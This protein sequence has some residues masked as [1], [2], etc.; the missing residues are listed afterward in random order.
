[1]KYPICCFLLS[2][3]CFS[4]SCECLFAAPAT[5]EKKQTV[6]TADRMSYMQDQNVIFFEE[7]VKVTNPDYTMT[8]RKMTVYLKDKKNKS[9]NKGNGNGR[10]IDKV[11]AVGNVVMINKG[12]DQ[13]GK[14]ID[15]ESRSKEAV[16][17]EGEKEDG[18]DN[19]VILT[20]DAT[21]RDGVNTLWGRKITVWLK[22]NRMECEP[23]RLILE[24]AGDISGKGSGK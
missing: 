8:A 5:G 1:M 12:V 20:G 21:V 18:S 22:E 24:E 23:S 19:I 13:N 2:V 15:R 17:I 3:F 11:T 9:K 16:Y 4:F 10:S 6:I 14:T 7:N